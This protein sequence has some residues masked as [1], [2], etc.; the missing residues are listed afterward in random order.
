MIRVNID[1]V[2]KEKKIMGRICKEKSG[3]LPLSSSDR[4]DKRNTM[5]SLQSSGL[6]RN[7]YVTWI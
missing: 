1:K 4:I 2:L 6:I 5:Q 7:K 3:S